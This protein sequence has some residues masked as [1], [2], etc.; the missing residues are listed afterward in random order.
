LLLAVLAAILAARLSGFREIGS[1]SSDTRSEQ[2]S[3]GPTT[4]SPDA[5]TG[6][7]VALAIQF[8]NDRE[9]RFDEVPWREGMT[10]DD[11]LTLASRQADGISYVVQGRKAMALLTRIDDAA[12]EGAGGR[13]WTY[14]V[15]D[16]RADRSFAVYELQPGDK[17]L[18]TFGLRE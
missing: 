13:N 17:V 4:K 3:T 11:L 8:G 5:A 7:T 16:Q 10:V 14:S 6:Q 18:W 12:N 2:S 15:N 1:T 9:R